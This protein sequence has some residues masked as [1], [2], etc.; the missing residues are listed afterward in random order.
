MPS[1]NP[2]SLDVETLILTSFV[3]IFQLT[4]CADLLGHS[5]DDV[6][7]W[8]LSLDEARHSHH[9][10]ITSLSTSSADPFCPSTSRRGG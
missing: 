9:F 10:I 8:R 3:L 1:I 5:A 6:P 2:G 4:Q 7:R